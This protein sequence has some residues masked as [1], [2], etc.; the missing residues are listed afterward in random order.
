[1]RTRVRFGCEEV[2]KV[3]PGRSVGQPATRE[4]SRS[5]LSSSSSLLASVLLAERTLGNRWV[6]RYIVPSERSILRDAKKP[7]A[8]KP[9]PPAKVTA[10]TINVP[11]LKDVGP[12]AVVL[13][14]PAAA[15]ALAGKNPEVHVLIHY[16]GHTGGY[17]DPAGVGKQRAAWDQI[18]PQIEATGRPMIAILP[19]A[20]IR[21]DESWGFGTAASK[22]TEYIAGVMAHLTT[23]EKWAVTPKF[24]VAV[25]GHS[26]GGFAAAS[27]LSAGL[28]AE[29]VMLFDG[30]NGPHELDSIVKWVTSRL[31]DAASRLQAAGTDAKKQD[32]ALASTVWF[33]A[34]HHG[35]DLDPVK[36][37][38]N[39]SEPFDKN[40]DAIARGYEGRYAILKDRVDKWFAQNGPKLGDAL[41]ARLR[42]HFEIKG[43]PGAGHEDIVGKSRGIEEGLKR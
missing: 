43:V 25:S 8:D 15:A 18:G 24:T 19:Q 2:R 11:A 9:A 5:P 41:A 21:A 13:I 28:K 7:E 16:H 39:L 37:K 35:R 14:T 40:S 29:A 10:R 31:D 36:D 3:S 38:V 26:G 34:Y 1:M 27:A 4:R 33:H 23:Q 32:E 22:P 30:I 17:G 20:G 12:A 42:G 6:Q